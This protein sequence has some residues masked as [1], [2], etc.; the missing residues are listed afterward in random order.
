MCLIRH[1]PSYQEGEIFMCFCYVC[2][3][4]AQKEEEEEEEEEE[5]IGS[6]FFN[7]VVCFVYSILF[8]QTF[9]HCNIVFLF[10]ITHVKGILSWWVVHVEKVLT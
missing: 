1:G 9:L 2:F 5:E 7:S 3:Y 6:F 8:L 10:I 4:V